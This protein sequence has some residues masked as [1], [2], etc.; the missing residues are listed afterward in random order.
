MILFYGIWTGSQSG[1]IEIYTPT[2]RASVFLDEK[3]VGVANTDGQVIT[4]KKVR[5]GEHSVLVYLEG[6]YPWEKTLTVYVNEKTRANAFFLREEYTSSYKKTEFTSLE[7]EAISLLFKENGSKKIS[8]SGDGNVEIKKDGGKIFASWL[9]GETTPSPAYFCKETK[10]S[11]TI[12]V[13]ESASGVIDTVDFYPNREDVILFSLEGGVYAIE[14][15][16]RGTQNFQPLYLGD[17]VSFRV[18]SE[19]HIFVKE[20]GEFFELIL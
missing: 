10:C 4:L 9:G 18:N 19:G 17:N 7:N 16:K 11:E 1:R 8:F 13:F 14:I 5:P 3:R 15:D 2:T 6:Y 12:L 20:K